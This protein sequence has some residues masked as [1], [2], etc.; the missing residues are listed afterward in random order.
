M[1]E[2]SFEQTLEE[3]SPCF[4]MVSLKKDVAFLGAYY[5]VFFDIQMTH[6]SEKNKKHNAD[7]MET[8]Q[9]SI[10][11]FIVLKLIKMSVLLFN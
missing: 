9:V 5:V 8:C 3:R 6:Q 2:F 4:L 1:E 11:I 7:E 10:T